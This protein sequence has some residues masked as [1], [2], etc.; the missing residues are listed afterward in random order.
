[1]KL[2]L[3]DNKVQFINFSKPSEED[4]ER[5]FD[6]D[7]NVTYDDKDETIFNVIFFLTLV[8]PQKFIL[9]IEYAS[10]FKADGELNEGFK[11]SHFPY[12]NAPAIAFPFLRSF[13]SLITL[14]SGYDAVILPSVNFTKFTNSNKEKSNS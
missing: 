12:V 4:D 10:T 11:E 1:M 5:K 14:H 3:L 2:Q 6:L 7:F 9:R 13:V 8:D